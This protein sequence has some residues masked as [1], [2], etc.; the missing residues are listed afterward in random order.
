[1]SPSFIACVETNERL[2]RPPGISNKTHDVWIWMGLATLSPVCL[3]S[4]YSTY[5][6][7][8]FFFFSR[9]RKV[10]VPVDLYGTWLNEHEEPTWLNPWKFIENPLAVFSWIARAT[11]GEAVL[12]SLD[13]G[14]VPSASPER[15]LKRPAKG[16]RFLDGWRRRRRRSIVRWAPHISFPHKHQTRL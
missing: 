7:I 10:I 2:S 5:I 13:T 1:M 8:K 14:S 4:K 6:I 11:L 9:A 3:L 15:R 16:G 12:F